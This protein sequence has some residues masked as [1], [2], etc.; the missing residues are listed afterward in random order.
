MVF[1][2]EEFVIFRWKELFG[3]GRLGQRREGIDGEVSIIGMLF[4]EVVPGFDFRIAVLKNINEAIDNVFYL[5][6]CE[7]GTY[8][9]DEA[10]YFLHTGLPPCG[11]ETALSPIFIG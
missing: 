6:F 11:V 7:L 10:G 5:A 9:D 4:V 1:A 3:L 2:K 8:P